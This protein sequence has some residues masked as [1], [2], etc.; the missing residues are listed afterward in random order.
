MN[1]KNVLQ[2]SIKIC[3]YQSLDCTTEYFQ[4]V[5]PFRKRKKNPKMT[6]KI[7]YDC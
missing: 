6:V 5:E 3:T 1:I 7:Y 4:I 2:L